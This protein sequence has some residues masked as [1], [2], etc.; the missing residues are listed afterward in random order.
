MAVSPG[1]HVSWATPPWEAA[2]P[3]RLITQQVLLL[4]AGLCKGVALLCSAPGEALKSRP[5]AIYQHLEGDK[6]AGG[7]HRDEL[8]CRHGSAWSVPF[9]YKFLLTVGFF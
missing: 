6:G 8:R 4:S 1:P 7:N 5:L 3:A 2:R 9:I